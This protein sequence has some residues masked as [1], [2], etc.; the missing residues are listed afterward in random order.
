MD[1]GPLGSAGL[2][3]LLA[4]TRIDD[5]TLTGHPSCTASVRLA[6]MLVYPYSGR[7]NRSPDAMDAPISRI[8][9][10]AIVS[11]DC[12]APH[13]CEQARDDEC[14][15]HRLPR[16]PGPLSVA[17]E[18]RSAVRARGSVGPVRRDRPSAWAAGPRPRPQRHD[19]F[20][21]HLGATLALGERLPPH[22][23]TLTQHYVGA[24]G[25]RVRVA[26]RT[27]SRAPALARCVRQGRRSRPG[28]AGPPS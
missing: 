21:Q 17:P 28:L 18:G 9:L 25:R 11:A 5:A 3:N 15:H 20:L 7:L 14:S 12:Q 26:A 22:S 2:T 8:S 13:R 24:P 4:A 23:G 16:R 6:N 10:R 1:G 27:V 19:V